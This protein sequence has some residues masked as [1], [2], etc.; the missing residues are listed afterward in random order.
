M[1]MN[2]HGASGNA[3]IYTRQQ[4]GHSAIMAILFGWLTCYIVP[5]YWLFSPNHYYHL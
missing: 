5:I 2:T 3:P 4:K 1:A